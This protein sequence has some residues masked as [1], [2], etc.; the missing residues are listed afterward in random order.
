MRVGLGGASEAVNLQDREV[1]SVGVN[2]HGDSLIVLSSGR[3][4][5]SIWNSSG[6]RLIYGS[7]R[8]CSRCSSR[9]WPRSTGRGA[10]HASIPSPRCVTIEPA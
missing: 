2:P 9:C 1:I 5:S 4:V 8:L 3:R 6:C 10:P 7:A